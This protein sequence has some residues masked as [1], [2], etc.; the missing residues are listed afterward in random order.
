MAKRRA[1]MGTAVKGLNGDILNAPGR[2]TGGSAI[3]SKTGLKV[4]K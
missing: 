2:V 3:L 1:L 4:S